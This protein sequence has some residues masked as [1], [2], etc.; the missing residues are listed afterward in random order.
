M[1][2][3]VF[4]MCAIGTYGSL[5]ANATKRDAEARTRTEVKIR[6]KKKKT[7]KKFPI[8]SYISISNVLISL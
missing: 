2:H 3:L 6:E 4:C 5:H 7:K 1:P 8:I